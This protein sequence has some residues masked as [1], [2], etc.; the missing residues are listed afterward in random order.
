MLNDNT[1]ISKP[2]N[3]EDFEEFC[4]IVYRVVFGD[5]NSEFQFPDDNIVR[6]GD[7]QRPPWQG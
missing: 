5:H 3:A 4:L 2:K 7:S 1:E 6:S